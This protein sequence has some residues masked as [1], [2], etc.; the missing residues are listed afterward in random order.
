MLGKVDGWKTYPPSAKF[1][2]AD[3]VGGSGEKD[4]EQAVIP[5]QPGRQSVPALAFSFFNPD[6]RQY[7]TKVTAPLSVE[8]SLSSASGLT[9]TGPVSKPGP[10]AASEPSRDGLRPDHVE[11][12]RTV[13]TLR[14]LY[15]QPWFVGAQGALVLCFAGGLIFLRRR[16]SRA[17]DTEGARQ[18]DLSETVASCRAE[19]DAASMSGDAARFFQSARAALQQNLAARW[20][21]TPASITIAEI[22]V[23]LNGEGGEIRR[24]FALADRAA[25]SG[26]PLSTADFQQWKEIICDQIQHTEAL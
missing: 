16:E 22:D 20:H 23:R 4:F 7:E 18:R 12:G 11:T 21:V 25:Y 6:T 14:P 9:A 1:Q 24:V 5:M 15:F 19:M 2:P 26:Q 10:T 13:V 3:S 8:V 17:N